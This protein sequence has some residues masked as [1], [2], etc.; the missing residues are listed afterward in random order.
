MR[1]APSGDSASTGFSG[2]SSCAGTVVSSDGSVVDSDSRV[3]ISKGR[4]VMS[5]GGTV[6]TRESA[7]DSG[8]SSVIPASCGVTIPDYIVAPYVRGV[9][10]A[11]GTER[12]F[13]HRI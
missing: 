1:G 11:H 10:S 8:G 3:V 2:R 9:S 6:F 13:P 4:V 5:V 12:T 7:G